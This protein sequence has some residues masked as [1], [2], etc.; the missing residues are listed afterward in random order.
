MEVLVTGSSGFVGSHLVEALV[1][2]KHRVRIL[3][4]PGMTLSPWLT[5]LPVIPVEAG[6]DDPQALRRALTGVTTIIHAGGVTRGIT[7]R[8]YYDG[9][10][11]PTLALLR[12]AV[13]L[14]KPPARFVL[15]SSHAMMG[16]APSPTE[17]SREDDMPMPVE[18]YGASKLAAELLARSFSHRIP[19]TIIRPPSV[20]G[21]RDRDFLVL[22]RQLARHCNLFYGN[23]DK[24]TGLVYVDDLVEGILKAAFSPRAVNRA[25]FICGEE[26]ITW[27]QLQKAI[28]EE[29]GCRA[30]T[31]R[32]P[33]CT[34]RLAAWA[35]GIKMRIT[36]RATL[37]NREKVRMGTPR[38]WCL[39]GERAARELGFRPAVSLAEG[40]RR[41]WAWYREQGWL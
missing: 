24:Y 18:A 33:A 32:I 22:F 31:I 40:I 15:I 19:V 16:P 2:R 8:D 6:Y 37:V 5:G 36:G 35:S 41:T 30:L 10:A 21:P 29:G 3:I 34:T 12:A 7:V 23:A 13:S 28:K 26:G 17:P 39:S 20:Y 1:A 14:K 4:R 9:N 27:R 25:Y 38:C 11:A